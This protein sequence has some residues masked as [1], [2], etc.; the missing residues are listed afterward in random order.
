M[1]AMLGCYA[2]LYGQ[3]YLMIIQNAM[4]Q[5]IGRDV[6]VESSED[7]SSDEVN[8]ARKEEETEV[9]DITTAA[10]TA[11]VRDEANN[12]GD[13]KKHGI[14]II[15]SGSSS[16]DG[17]G[18]ELVRLVVQRCRSA[19]LLVSC[20]DTKTNPEATSTTTVHSQGY[21]GIIAYV[22]FASTNHSTQEKLSMVFTAARTLLNLPLVTLGKWGDGS[23]AKSVLKM[24]SELDS[25][26]NVTDDA[27][28]N[29][30]ELKGIFVMVVPQ[31]NLICKV[32][33]VGKS[34]QYHQQ[35]NKDEGR[36]LYEDFIRA[37]KLVSLEHQLT[38]RNIAVPEHIRK[39]IKAYTELRKDQ[40]P[41]SC[42]PEQMFKNKSLYSSWD[43]SGFPLTNAEGDALA[44]TETKS[45]MKKLRKLFDA[46]KKRYSKYMQSGVSKEKGSGGEDTFKALH[47][48]D[49]FIS[50]IPGTFG[51]LQALHLSSDM[52][53]F[54]HVVNL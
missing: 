38:S 19:S 2:L 43:D 1:T 8:F 15:E 24:A 14:V 11:P 29:N 7:A 36:R 12:D 52:G 4:L 9:W 18:G 10:V 42:P 54:C 44:V 28:A 51:N 30:D 49:A 22:S 27:T 13:D 16:S 20:E 50:I 26:D 17:E 53:P 39:S 45:T 40:T 32:K 48:D 41:P 5:Y 6:N 33:N 25:S 46:Q 47:L 35:I 31:A 23:R 3:E 37:L 21:A 34:V